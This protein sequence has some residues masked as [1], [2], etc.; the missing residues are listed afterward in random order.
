MALVKKT[1]YETE[2]NLVMK[3]HFGGL[4]CLKKQ[5]LYTRR[6]I[7]FLGVLVGRRDFCFK[8]YIPNKIHFKNMITKSKK[9]ART[10]AVDIII[11]VYNG[12]KFLDP[13]FE[14]LLK[15]TDLPFRLLVID[16]HSPDER[17]FPLLKKWQQKF[18]DNA[19]LFQ[20]KENLGFVRTVNFGLAN[21][22]NHVVLLNTD[23][24]VPKNWLSRLMMPIF[25]NRRIASVTPFSNGGTIYSFPELYINNPL[26]ADYQ[27]IDNCLARLDMKNT[28]SNRLRF[29]TGIGFC[30]AMN[31][32]ALAKVGNLDEVFGRGYGEENDWCMRACNLGY[33]H[34]VAYNLFVWHNQGGSFDKQDTKDL[35]DKN[36]R[37]LSARYADYGQ[38]LNKSGN[39]PLYQSILFFAR[40]IVFNKYAQKSTLVFDS[41]FD[42]DAPIS[43]DGELLLILS[44][45]RP[46]K[47]YVLTGVHDKDVHILF[48]SNLDNLLY[49]LNQMKFDLV[50]VKK[51]SGFKKNKRIE[52]FIKNIGGVK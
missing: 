49:L 3:Y 52:S 44:Y 48:D 43:T 41:D 9:N 46:F 34:T 7:W 28:I 12:Y 14:S 5:W 29:P 38:L 45:N 42:T 47:S 10:E 8:K 31:K 13:L 25:N 24:V 21:A 37:L 18:G 6:F 20:N 22:K 16:D 15:N 50:D 51:L 32:K 35:M 39:S 33:F 19:L 26:I 2:S 4:C 40:M 1:T 30:M 27:D 11:P 23:V 36:C 17:V